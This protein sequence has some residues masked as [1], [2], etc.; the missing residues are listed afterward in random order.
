MEVSPQET[1][2]ESKKSYQLEEE[3]VRQRDFKQ[4]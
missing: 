1:H 2:A 4:F 3:F